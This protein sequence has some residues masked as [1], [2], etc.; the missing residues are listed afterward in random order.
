MKIK[1]E[2]ISKMDDDVFAV[3]NHGN[4]KEKDIIDA[5]VKYGRGAHLSNIE[6]RC[7]R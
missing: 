6:T 4:F 1:P 3:D 7:L 5:L 2:F